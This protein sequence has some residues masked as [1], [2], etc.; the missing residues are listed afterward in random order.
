MKKLTLIF[1]ALVL[2]ATPAVWAADSGGKMPVEEA[3]TADPAPLTEEQFKEMTKRLGKENDCIFLRTIDGWTAIDR[4][5]L[6][7][8]APN[9][10][11][12]YL[13]EIAPSVNNILFEET[14]ALY[15]KT[16][17]RLCP[18]GRS[19]LLLKDERLFIKGI[20][21][22]TKEEAQQLKAYKR[23]KKNK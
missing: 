8:Y 7:L 19:G 21:K 18:Y 5:H 6:L 9:R 13:L 1:A 14:L 4:T 12:P 23:A 10:N 20:A 3:A 22:I 2:F 15:S 11:H 17:E 16:G